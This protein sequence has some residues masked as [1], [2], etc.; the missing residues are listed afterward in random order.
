MVEGE[1]RPALNDAVELALSSDLR[2][3]SSLHAE[4]DGQCLVSIRQFSMDCRHLGVGRVI[5]HVPLKMLAIG[6]IAGVNIVAHIPQTQY[7][8]AGS[9]RPSRTAAQGGTAPC[10]KLSNCDH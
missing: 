6:K 4:H 5:A 7:L 10:R 8:N 2:S 1:R 3:G 9:D